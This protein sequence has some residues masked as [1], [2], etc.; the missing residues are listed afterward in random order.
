[1]EEQSK[2]PE[3]VLETSQSVTARAS[4]EHRRTKPLQIVFLLLVVGV[5]GFGGGWLG[6]AN[7]ETDHTPEAQRIV[8][9]EQSNLISGIA[10]DVGKSVVSVNVTSETVYGGSFFG[11]GRTLQQQSA[12]TGIILSKEG[13]IIT[14]RHVVPEGTT[15]VSVT[16]S[17]GTTLD[18]VK[19]VGRTN[20]SDTLDVAFLQIT[21]SKGQDLIP[22]KI[23]ASSKVR[24]GD[25]VVAIGNALGQFQNTVT[26]GILSGY[27]RSVE[28][29]SESGEGSESL[30]NLFQTDAAINQ[31][32][33][34]GPLVN[35]RGEVIGINT[36]VAGGDAENIGF[37][38]PID[39][40]K[41]LIASVTRNGKIERPYLGVVYVPLTDAL[42]KQY[43]LSTARGAFIPKA[44]DYGQETVYA[45]GPA[46]KAGV[47]D[48][49]VITKVDGA[50]VNEQASLASLLGKHQPGDTVKLTIS[51]DSKTQD[52]SV[53]LSTMPASA[54]N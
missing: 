53:K 19:V 2:Q 37:A 14:N 38:I 41:G 17:D 26:T 42:A 52:I 47:R 31:G 29:Q 50:A 10:K 23:G 46:A 12:G 43:S 16:L 18:N 4:H 36:A 9:D 21:D 7:R 13:L 35:L 5:V 51:R 25:S 1:M 20:S 15:A 27:G 45:D 28:A 3:T 24:V 32:N 33:S 39:N 11:G 44:S 6:A 22:A 34:G 48:G 49:D 8:L 30:D 40:V 54:A